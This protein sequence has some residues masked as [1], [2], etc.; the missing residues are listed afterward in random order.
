MPNYMQSSVSG[1]KYVRAKRVVL[2]NPLNGVPSATFIEQEVI[3]IGAAESVKRDVG[4]LHQPMSDPYVTFQLLNP[5]DDS[6]IGS[7][8]YA[9]VYAM[10]Y[11]LHRHLAAIR[12][13]NA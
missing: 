2:E 8:T 1:E 4:A 9:D 12:D 10:L 13:A 6:V 11:S 5:V 7:A 3:N